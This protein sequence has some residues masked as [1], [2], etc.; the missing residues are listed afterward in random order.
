MKDTESRGVNDTGK[1]LLP[2]DLSAQ[3][4]K[5]PCRPR[6]VAS[7]QLRRSATRLWLCAL[8]WG[9]ECG[10]LEKG[11]DMEMI[12]HLMSVVVLVS[13]LLPLQS[14]EWRDAARGQRERAD[15][16]RERGLQVCRRHEFL[17]G[18][19]F[20]RK[21]IFREDYSDRNFHWCTL[22]NTFNGEIVNAGFA[23]TGLRILRSFRWQDGVKRSETWL[24]DEKG[25]W[26]GREEVSNVCF[27]ALYYLNGNTRQTE[28]TFDTERGPV[29]RG[30][31]YFFDM[32]GE[33]SSFDDVDGILQ[34]EA[35]VK[36][37]LLIRM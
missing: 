18:G 26:S 24:F 12:K 33:P 27:S 23:G 4:A 37:E 31:M 8:T 17:D 10:H 1:D 14:G 7:E 28:T 34:R 6:R 21:E 22:T 5:Y 2:R 16:L 15:R 11:K 9:M 32:N 3:R 35:P 20:R 29:Y 13:A 36:F 19:I 25:M 30:R